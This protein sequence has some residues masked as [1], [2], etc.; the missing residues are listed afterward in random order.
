MKK[1]NLMHRA[2]SYLCIPALVL[3]LTMCSAGVGPGEV[4]QSTPVI[5]PAELTEACGFKVGDRA[6]NFELISQDGTVTSLY[7]FSGKA[8]VIDFSTMWCGP[9]QLAARTIQETQEKYGENTFVYLTILVDNFQGKP[10]TQSELQQWATYFNIEMP[11][12]SGQREMLDSTGEN[13]WHL[14]YWPTFV[15]IDYDMVIL[16]YMDGWSEE[17]LQDKINKLVLGKLG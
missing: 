17:I 13:G 3:T 7:D 16:E 10:P 4:P 9:C 11:I 2:L 15:F 14:N 1:H 12:M 6:C 5:P 8:I